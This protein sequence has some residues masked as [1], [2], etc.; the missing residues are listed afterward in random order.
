MSDKVMEKTSK[1]RGDTA[2]FPSSRIVPIN[3]QN[4]DGE[5]S[6]NIW[7]FADTSYQITDD[8]QVEITGKRYASSGQKLPSLLPWITGI[9]HIDAPKKQHI[10]PGPVVQMLP[11]AITNDVF[12]SQMKQI[13]TDEQLS[14]DPLVRLRHGHG[15]SLEDMYETNYATIKRIPDIVLYPQDTAQVQAIVAFARSSKVL[16]LP[17]GGGTNV[18]GALACPAGESRMIAAVSMK[19]MDRILWIDKAN[20]LARIEAGA[21]GR[22]IMSTLAEHRLTLGHEPDSVEFSTLGGWIATKASGMKRSRYGNI[23]D[24]VLDVEM[25]TPDGVLGRL[26]ETTPPRESLGIDIR[27]WA[28]GSEGS[29][30]IITSAVVKVFPLPEVQR[31][32]SLLFRS[33]DAGLAFVHDLARS[34][35]QPASVRLV[36]N[37]Q[38][39][40]SI[41]LKPHTTGFVQTLKSKLEKAYVTRLRGFDPHQMVAC[42]LVF[43]GSTQQ[44]KGQASTVSSLAR[45]HGGLKAGV[46]N[47]RRGYE[48]T[49]AI[50]YI[51]DF[52]MTLDIYAESFET[53][54]A[55][56][57]A[58]GLVQRVRARIE[59]EHTA[60]DLP[61]KPFISGRLSQAYDTGV[62]IYFYM[63]IF[64]QGVGD[65]A[66]AYA[67]LEEAARDEIL[68]CGGA[69]SHHHGVGTLR[70][71]FLPRVLSSAAM[72]ARQQ[73]KQVLDSDDVFVGGRDTDF[74]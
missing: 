65:P 66:G 62:T 68:L 16:I 55:W 57:A 73:L 63:A 24:I 7:G 74:P 20:Q 5:E 26:T 28:F 3:H 47:G 58:P 36:D 17:Y 37:T 42:T 60:L 54:C 30:G 59:N 48:L 29:L 49:F 40:F 33:F 14:H 45:R 72:S 22:H 9:M 64:V 56:T 4:Q 19:R 46:D 13:L 27:S 8:G 35:Q 15:Q 52:A 1:S 12:L 69:V 21:V 34:G 11:S 18:S 10:V 39:Q 44:V 43:E 53:S 71:K 38:F 6:C 70:R 50:A 31:Y 25:V 51:R 61:G 2:S 23:E 32:G 41:A 67:A